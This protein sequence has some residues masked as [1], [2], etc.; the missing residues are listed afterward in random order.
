MK[1]VVKG[2]TLIELMIVVAI[3]GILAAI[4]I[5]NFLRYQLRAKFSELKENVGSVFKSEEALRQGERVLGGIAGQ[6]YA[7]GAMP[8]TCTP[9]T[10]KNSWLQT[11][12]SNAQQIDWIIEGNTYGC[13]NIGTSSF[14][15]GQSGINLTVQA[16]S[17]IDGDADSA[18]VVLY[19]PTLGSNGAP[20]VN[21]LTASCTVVGA[22][23][24]N[25]TAPPYGQPY[26]VGASGDSIF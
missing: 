24:P 14:T 11:D 23:T 18:C 25:G 9:G 6:Y 15:N 26:T 4:A 16:V 20:T 12:L 5:P 2:F 13:Y 19:K 17:N 7:L 22:T 3:I 1:K 8:A 21:P 10:T